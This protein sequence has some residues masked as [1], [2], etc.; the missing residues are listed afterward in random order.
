MTLNKGLEMEV[1]L[2]QKNLFRVLLVE[3]NPTDSSVIC[4]QLKYGRETTFELEV[5]DRVSKALMLLEER[6]FDVILLDLSLPD[7]EKLEALDA[8]SANRINLPIVI[9]TGLNDGDL[10]VSAVR[11]GAQDYLIKG[12]FNGDSLTR[13]IKYALERK[14]LEK[15]L[16]K[17]EEQYRSLF[18]GVPIGLYRTTPRGK[19]I[20]ANPTFL[21]MVGYSSLKDLSSLNA[22]ELASELGYSRDVFRELMMSDG[23]VIGLEAQITRR[24]GSSISIRE[25]AKAV[26]DVNG[27]V[28]YYEGTFED[29]SKQKQVEEALRL[30][31][32]K[33]RTLFNNANDA[34]FLIEI[35]GGVPGK[36]IEVNE[37]ACDRLGYS[38]AELL[39]MSPADFSEP[40][41]FQEALPKIKK[42]FLTQGSTTLEMIQITKYERKIPVEISSHLFKFKGKSVALSIVRDITDRKDAEKAQRE[43]EEKFRTLFETSPDAIVFAQLDGKI[44]TANQAYTDLVGYDIQELHSRT[45][46][47]F[48]PKKWEVIESKILE[49]QILEEGYSEIYEKEYIRKDGTIIPVETRAILLK[50]E[51]D[52]PPNIF[53]IIRDITS[54]K[55][56][57]EELN[58]RTNDLKERVKELDCLYSVSELIMDPRRQLKDVF[59]EILALIPLTWQYPE[60]TTARIIYDGKEY[61]TKNFQD[62]PWKLSTD[63]LI[64]GKKVGI[65]EVFY[66]QEKI[67]KYEG[68]FLKEE[69]KLIDTIALKIGNFLELKESKNRLNFERESLQRILDSMEDA[70]NIVDDKYEVEFMN[71]VFEKELGPVEG[72]KCYTY[73]HDRDDPCPWCPKDMVL[74][75]ETVHWEWFSPKKQRTYDIIDTPLKN[76]DGSYSKLRISRDIT[77]RKKMEESL[78]ESEERFRLIFTQVF[79]ALLITD[80]RGQIV[81]LNEAACSLLGYKR[82][83]IGQLFL[84]DVLSKKE[85]KK[86]LALINRV[87]QGSSTHLG[88][89]TFQKKDNTQIITEG[90]GTTIEISGDRYFVGSFRDITERIRWEEELKNRL[91]KF[92]IEDGKV[93]LIKESTPSLSINV[94]TDLLEVGYNGQII[95]RTLE[96]DLKNTI[97]RDFDY[98]WLTENNKKEYI[99]VFK[100]I[101]LII[102]EK[103]RRNVILIERLDYLVSLYGFNE[104]VKLVYKLRETAYLKSLVVLLSI[105]TAT[106]NGQEL[107]LLEKETNEITPRFMIKIPDELLEILRFVY[108]MNNLGMKPSYSEVRDE[109]QISRPTVSKRIKQLVATGHLTENR[110]GNRKTLELSQ[111]GRLL[112]TI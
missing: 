91:M 57:E 27:S 41:T 88:Q 6:N 16:K 35:N 34:I 66:T 77:D 21:D 96:R 31:E 107:S 89:I 1:V 19:F 63:L 83:E 108:K 76:F 92:N 90:G 64:S 68:P 24:D 73:F 39:T 15:T 14:Q 69:R 4:E 46:Q 61:V 47:D 111:K 54:R 85:F 101:E 10:A 50:D 23:A 95:S 2:E 112:F 42:D 17:S 98:L 20:A 52:K 29:I 70:V 7:A 44:L 94:F 32:E 58:K 79:D 105:D 84:R 18:E 102:E 86:M 60:I 40:I 74:V 13:A 49:N 81:D 36:V 75:G 45:V 82:E 3:D 97:D 93:Y 8:F 30:S 100:E 26:T 110:K 67:G 11:K 71:S 37:I 43:S 51:T 38:R 5:A 33:Y 28:I 87:L 56:S 109:I 12:E 22:D 78:R 72:K 80:K 55:K 25:N 53:H 99:S 106:I 104:T 59:K 9:L 65:I 62:S 48:T 103:P